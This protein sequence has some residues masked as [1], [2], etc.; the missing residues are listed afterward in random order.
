MK[1][2]EYQAKELLA[3][4]GLPI[5]S[6]GVAES[7]EEALEVAKKLASR[8]LV[9]KAQVHAGGR[10]KAGG[11]ALVSS[12]AELKDAAK[13]ILALKLKTAQTA[14]EGIRVSKILI[15]T[16]AD[17]VKELYLGI[18]IDRERGLPCIIFST[19]GGMEIEE[20]AR[21][22]PEKI[23]KLHFDPV[24]GLAE[25]RARE[26]VLS[27]GLPLV[28]VQVITRL[29]KVFVDLDCSLLEINPL[30]I[31][32]KG[33]VTLVDAKIILDDNGL[34]R[35]PEL[36]GLRDE[37]EEDSREIEASK[38]GLSYVGLDGTI[39]CMVNGA[40]L[41]MATMDLIKLAGGEPANFLDVGGSATTEKV[42][43]A[44]K[45]ILRDPRVKAVLVN[46]FGG[47]M[48]CDVIAQGIIDALKEVKMTVPLVVRLEGTNVEKGKELLKHSK[49]SI[50]TASELKE[51]AEK[52]VTSIH[53]H[54][55]Q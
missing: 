17:I 46:I 16:R 38:F 8:E 6:G 12:E 53:G 54:P 23:I 40:G 31:G 10:G 32:S 47:I 14:G 33:Q 48:K 51:A 15:E 37:K 45:I 9:V 18:T 27:Q 55:R 20:L 24:I 28:L 19:S 13:R 21:R 39:G 36:E 1:L 29:A 11:I 49:I 5:Q 3:K 52:V 2:H 26:L 44:F 35:H 22:S 41:A 4:F 50:I 30:A 25:F 42:T 7:V 43:A 34:A